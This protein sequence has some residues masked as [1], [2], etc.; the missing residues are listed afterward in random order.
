MIVLNTIVGKILEDFK[1]EVD[2]FIEKGEK[3]EVAILKVLRTYIT[4]SK[5]IIFEGDNYSKE[6]EKEAAKRGL[7][8][9]KTTPHALDF[10]LSKK[11][12]ELFTQSGVLSEEELEA[13][14]EIQQEIYAKKLD[15]ETKVLR[16]LIW[17]YVIPAAVKY[18]NILLEN[19]NG[20]KAARA[21]ATSY[22]AQTDLINSI[23]KHINSLKTNVD[24]MLAEKEKADKAKSAHQR[25]LYYCDKVKPYFDI[26]RSHAD[27]LELLCDDSL[28][29]L[30]KYRDLL[31]VK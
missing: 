1:K 27:Q 15:I 11:S 14:Y 28:W 8:N 25:A 23:S 29:P 10:Y 4:S 5:K 20:L 2:A 22:K 12:R 16:D 30:P 18:Q 24:K 3:K 9:V 13:R 31:F 26:I 6:W 17:S 19:V 21:S 7:S